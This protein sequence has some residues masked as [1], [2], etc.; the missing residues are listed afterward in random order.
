MN[1]ETGTP[2]SDKQL[3]EAFDKVC[4]KSNWKNPIKGLCKPEDQDVV[5][6]AIIYFTGSVPEFRKVKSTGMLRVTAAG[7]YL[8]IGS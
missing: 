3:H 5:T 8:T 4:D 1:A 6:E 2:Y 7:Y